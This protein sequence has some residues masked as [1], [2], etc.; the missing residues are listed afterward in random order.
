MSNY[1]HGNWY[2]KPANETEA[3]EIFQRALESGA[4]KDETLKNYS[5]DEYGAWGVRNGLTHTQR[6]DFYRY[7][8]AIEYTIEQVRELFLL[9]SEQANKGWNGEGSPQVGQR[10]EINTG[11]FGSYRRKNGETGRV[12]SVSTN[13][14]DLTIAM[15][16]ID[17]A[18]GE[19]DAVL[20]RCLRPIPSERER[21]VESALEVYCPS[22]VGDEWDAT[23]DCLGA[24]YD[25]IKSGDLK[26]PEA[27]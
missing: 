14:R 25:A 24:V 27:E 10:V 26:A 18:G 4:E 22:T 7:E 19:C 6:M 5:W 21:W 3:R 12:L 8:D 1:K 11:N 15:I 16:E 2:C 23:I 9:P 17:G 13:S 20:V